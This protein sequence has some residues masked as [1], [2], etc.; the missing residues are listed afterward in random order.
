MIVSQIPSISGSH[1]EERRAA[2]RPEK[3]SVADLKLIILSA[4]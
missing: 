4:R 2:N 1:D 3:N